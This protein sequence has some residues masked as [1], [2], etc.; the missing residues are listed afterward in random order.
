MPAGSSDGS[1]SNTRNALSPVL[2]SGWAAGLVAH[3]ATVWS[4]NG[5]SNL[6]AERSAQST[7]GV[8]PEKSNLIGAQRARS[9]ISISRP[10]AGPGTRSRS[11]FGPIR[12]AAPQAAL[13]GLKPEKAQCFWRQIAAPRYG[14]ELH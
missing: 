9:A 6:S 5:S 7:V 4:K 2:T 12:S 3:R 14:R 13:E 8:G 1:L 11:G 10:G